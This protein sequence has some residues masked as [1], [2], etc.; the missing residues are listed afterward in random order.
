MDQPNL[1]AREEIARRR[2]DGGRK[3]ERV[4]ALDATTLWEPTHKRAPPEKLRSAELGSGK[5]NLSSFLA[6]DGVLTTTVDWNPD[7]GADDQRDFLSLPLNYLHPF[8]IT[9]ISQDCF[10]YSNLA[11]GKHRTRQNP[12]GH[13]AAAARANRELDHLVAM[14]DSALTVDPS[15]LFL[16]E[17]PVGMLQHTKGARKGLEK[18]C[19]LTKLEVCYCKFMM[20]GATD[21]VKKPTHFW[22]NCQLLIDAFGEGKFRCTAQT[23][24]S[25]GDGYH[26]RVRPEAGQEGDRARDHAAFPDEVARFL[27]LMLINE[28]RARY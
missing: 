7:C 15:K 8:D 22:T 14:I 19:G 2:R 21:Y 16:F 3:R 11:G 4:E 5:G 17:N 9:H 12:E 1:R 28:A 20:R 24:C 26:R 18:K 25:C 27:A 10:T 23:P 6:K 13:S